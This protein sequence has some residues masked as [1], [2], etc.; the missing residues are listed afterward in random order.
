[1]NPYTPPNPAHIFPYAIYLDH[2][3][4]GLP[5]PVN[6]RTNGTRPIITWLKIKH[7]II[8]QVLEMSACMLSQ[9]QSILEIISKGM[10]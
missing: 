7:M 8:D 10:I 1:M 5:A 4:S 3:P 9:K 6:I 2:I